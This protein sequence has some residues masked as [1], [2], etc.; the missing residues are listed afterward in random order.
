MTLDIDNVRGQGYDNGF[1]MKEKNRD[2][3]KRLLDLN[4]RV[5]CTPCG[6]HSL[7]AKRETFLE[8]SSVFT[9]CLQIPLKD[10]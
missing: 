9:L 2:V 5:F 7:K 10:G 8:L 1:N 3:Q 4:P 6:F